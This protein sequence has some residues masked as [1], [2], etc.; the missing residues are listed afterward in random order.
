[1]RLMNSLW[2]KAAKEGFSPESRNRLVTTFLARA[3]RILP[4]VR[5]EIVSQLGKKEK[6]SQ[7]KPIGG[8]AKP[9]SSNSSGSKKIDYS[10]FKSDR[11]LMDALV[12][13]KG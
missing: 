1:M 7:P 12:D 3:K 2:Q 6:V 9:A 5:K 11:E 4:A 10:Q 8:K 13:K